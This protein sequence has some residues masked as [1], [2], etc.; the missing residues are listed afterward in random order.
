MVK[1]L[2]MLIFAFPALA[3]DEMFVVAFEPEPK[4]LVPFN[5]VLTA[6]REDVSG[7]KVRFVM[8]KMYMGDFNFVPS[9]ENGK[10]MVR[11]IILPV[12][13]SHLWQLII[14]YNG[15]NAQV[16]EFEVK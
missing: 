4:P 12:C 9:L 5:L 11:N 8:P 14:E 3:A 2:V 7:I 1:L 13:S 6:K 10:Y 16:V 15:K